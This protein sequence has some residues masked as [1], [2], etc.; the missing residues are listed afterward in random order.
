MNNGTGLFDEVVF[1]GDP[2]SDENYVQFQS[3]VI[4]SDHIRLW[5][6]DTFA[7]ENNGIV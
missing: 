7:E 2:S 5:F 4:D 3:E 6:N 1:S